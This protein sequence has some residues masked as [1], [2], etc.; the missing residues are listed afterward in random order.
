[1]EAMTKWSDGFRLAEVDLQIR[2]PGALEGIRQSGL[3]EF[4]FA[5]IVRDGKILASARSMAKKILSE[6]P[7]LRD[8]RNAQMRQEVMR[9]YAA[10]FQLGRL[11]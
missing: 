11:Q 6:D 10:S 9:R 3:P 5:D 2:G 1:M 7:S 4:R 8:R